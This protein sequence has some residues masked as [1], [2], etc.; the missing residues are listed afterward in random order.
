MNTIDHTADPDLEE[1]LADEETDEITPSRAGR[2]AY[3]ASWARA[4][5]S[6]RVNAQEVRRQHEDRVA[7]RASKNAK[8]QAVRRKAEAS[9]KVADP[10]HDARD[11]R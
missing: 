9:A 3:A 5:R 8:A 7:K 10:G 4:E 1:L 2:R 6:F 11:A